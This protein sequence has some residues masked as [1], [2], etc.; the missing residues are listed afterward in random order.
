MNNRA[1]TLLVVAVLWTLPAFGQVSPGEATEAIENAEVHADFAARAGAKRYAPTLIEDAMIRLERAKEELADNE[2]SRALRAALE[3]TEASIAAESKA[4]W[5]STVAEIRTL[6]GD[7]ERLGATLDPLALVDEQAVVLLD[8][9]TSRERVAQA[10]ELVDTARALRPTGAE[11]AE[12]DRADVLLGSA[13]KIVDKAKNNSTADHLA[14]VASMMARQAIYLTRLREL[15]GVLPELRLR[16]TELAQAE[17]AREAEQERRQ[18]EQ[19]ERE[20]ETVRQR[21]ETEQSERAAEQ[22]EIQRLRENLQKQQEILTAEL[23]GVRTARIEAEQRLDLL[24]AQYEAALR[25]ASTDSSEIE[26]LRQRVEDQ[27]LRLTEMRRSEDQTEMALLRE[28]EALREDLRDERERGRIPD[29]ELRRQEQQLRTREAQIE[30][31][32]RDRNEALE[33][34]R[35]AEEQFRER[36][37]EAEQQMRETMREREELQ[38]RL[39]EE[40]AAREQAERELERMRAEVAERERIERVRREELDAM[41]AQLAELAETRA[42]ER[43][44]IV[45][46]PGLFFDTGKSTLKAG[47]QANLTK[48]AGLLEQMDRVRIIVEGHTDSVG[49]EQMNQRLSESRADAVRDYLVAEGVSPTEITTVGRGESQPIA[50]NET[51]EGRSKN[52]RVEIVIEELD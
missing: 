11:G 48:I 10:R 7:L 28:I 9:E 20:L 36:I 39:T 50:T 16:R 23:S 51:A 24:R 40:R 26:T 27:E 25:N 52:R 14:Y 30:Q 6:R 44:F 22:A 4:R 49:A 15:S 8:A 46:L 47:T 34:R 13:E 45:T 35:R 5:L 19:A 18:R 33:E 41:K 3:S 32:R 31:L 12:L 42:D 21:L 2:E 17:A 37:V 1:M 43:G 29:E 38:S